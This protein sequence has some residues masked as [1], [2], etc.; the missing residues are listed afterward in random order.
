MNISVVTIVKN[1]RA[2]LLNMI[3]GLERCTTKPAQLIVI[4]MNEVPYSLPTTTFPV[5][6]H[7][8]HSGHKLPLAAARNLAIKSAR[9]E[10]VIFLDADCIPAIDFLCVYRKAFNQDDLLFSGKVRYLS[11]HAMEK[12]DVFEKMVEYSM[13]DPVREGIDQYPYA[14]FWSINFACSKTV[15]NRIGGFDEFFTGYGAEDTDFAFSARSSGV[16]MK[17]VNAMAFHQYHPSYDPPINHLID[18]ISNAKTF[19]E[20]WGMWPMEG[21]L[22]KFQQRGMISW[23]R[24][25]LELLRMP[26]EQEIQQALKAT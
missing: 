24:L 4:H 26:S 16:E 11:A 1:R 18:I 13:P 14:L 23:T 9:F 20:K 12:I 10:Q 21:W 7:V 6:A 15:F 3:R 19:R 8:L 2:A 5:H 25:H 22:K 17:T